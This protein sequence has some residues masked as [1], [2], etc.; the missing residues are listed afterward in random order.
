MPNAEKR[1]PMQDAVIISTGQIFS[2]L[3]LIK[4]KNAAT[5]PQMPGSSETAV[6]PQIL[7]VSP[8]ENVE[9]SA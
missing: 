6:K 1:I 9:S 8:K 3:F 5:A 2:L 4:K 7:S